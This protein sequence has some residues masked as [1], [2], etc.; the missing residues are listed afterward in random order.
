VWLDRF[1]DLLPDGFEF[2]L[3]DVGAADGLHPCWAP[4]RSVVS[5]LLFEPRENVADVVRQGRDVIYPI[6]LDRASGMTSLNLTASI[7]MSSSLTPNAAIFDTFQRKREHTQIVGTMP[8]R[9]DTLDAIVLRDGHTVDAIKVD[10]QGSELEILQGAASCLE[11]TVLLAE[12]EVSFFERYVGQARFDEIVGF[13]RERGFDLLDLHRLRR[14]R[15]RNQAG[16][17]NVSFG[18]GRRAGRLAYGDALFV[19]EEKRLLARLEAMPAPEAE[20]AALRAILG[21]LIYGKPDAAGRLFDL[22]A[23][24]FEPKRREL[25]AGALRHLRLRWVRNSG[26][27]RIFDFLCR[28]V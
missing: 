11:E 15:Q 9:V 10:T 1:L 22:T 20:V 13:M 8:I 24:M 7:N 25:L 26:A 2:V 19:L 12:I 3:A 28:R 21:L 18:F 17:G 6:G 14:Y 27:N 23:E 5:A 16:I 4:A